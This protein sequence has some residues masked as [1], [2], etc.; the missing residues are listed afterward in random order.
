MGLVSSVAFVRQRLQS[1][2]NRPAATQ[3]PEYRIRQAL[4]AHQATCPNHKGQP[5]HNPTARWVFQYFVG[6]HLLRV[7][8]RDQPQGKILARWRCTAATVWGLRADGGP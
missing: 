5:V 4:K 8:R 3:I 7:P 6:L 1:C 2:T